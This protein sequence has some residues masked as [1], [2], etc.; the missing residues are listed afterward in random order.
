M[1]SRQLELFVQVASSGSL[2]RAAIHTSVA[3]PRL[4]RVIKD[5]EIEL[6]TPLFHRTGRGVVLTEAGKRLLTRAQAILADIREA[7]SEALESGRSAVSSATIAFP[8]AIA[9]VFSGPLAWSL[10]NKFP[11]IKL[12]FAEAYNSH[13]LDWLANG[14]IELAVV[15]KSRPAQQ[16]HFEPLLSEQ[17]YVVASTSQPQ[18]PSAFPL[19]SIAT[20]P[21]IM[22]GTPHGLRLLLETIAAKHDIH[23]SIVTEAD[24]VGIMI[25]LVAMGL[26]YTVLPLASV[27]REVESGRL[28]ASPLVAPAVRR[29]MGLATAVNR[30]LAAGTHEIIKE[31]KTLV[32]TMGKEAGWSKVTRCAATSASKSAST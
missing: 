6:A 27:R 11:G 23:L 22:R 25:D 17:L 19:E 18:L 13:L 31:I 30:P 8:P 12:R 26:G 9:R 4:T 28:Q 2:S 24:G 16:F 29:T 1:D 21:L 20:L 15:Y 10:S 3:Q 5:L 14:S 32:A 7:K